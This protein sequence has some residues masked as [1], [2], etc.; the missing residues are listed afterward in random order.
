[1]ASPASFSPIPQQT[2]T[3]L[4][5][6]KSISQPPKANVR[7]EAI[8]TTGKRKERGDELLKSAQMECKPGGAFEAETPKAKRAKVEVVK[9]AALNSPKAQ[10]IEQE[11]SSPVPSPIPTFIATGST[12][13]PLPINSSTPTPP[14][15]SLDEDASEDLSV[16]GLMVDI[17]LSNI[18]KVD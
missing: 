16:G 7:P 3:V 9:S 14:P 1:M 2:F 17:Q 10:V 13:N 12:L 6:T 8:V 18:L 15:L 11:D 4:E 5:F